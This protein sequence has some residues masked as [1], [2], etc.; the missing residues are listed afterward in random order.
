MGMKIF[1]RLRKTRL[2]P[3]QLGEQAAKAPQEAA[4][5]LGAHYD[6]EEIIQQKCGGGR[7]HSHSHLEG[8]DF[9]IAP[10]AVVTFAPGLPAKR[11]RPPLRSANDP[12]GFLAGRND[13]M[14]LIVF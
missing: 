3:F 14:A 13:S 9:S 11:N 10:W 6:L 8:E 7:G 2:L 12:E 5:L 4:R 1:L